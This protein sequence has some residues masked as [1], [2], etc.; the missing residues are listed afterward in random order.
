MA[1]QLFELGGRKCGGRAAADVKGADVQP[2]AVSSFTDGGQLFA[3]FIHVGLHEGAG[4]LIPHRAGDKAAIAAPR[5][6]ERDAR[7]DAA[8]H[9]VSGIQHG[10]L[11]IGNAERE[12]EF[13][14]CAAKMAEKFL[15]DGVLALPRCAQVVDDAHRA[16]AG[17]HAPGR[18]DAGRFTQQAKFELAQGVFGVS[19]GAAQIGAPVQAAVLA[20][21]DQVGQFVAFRQDK[22]LGLG[23]NFC[24]FSTGEKDTRRVLGF[25]TGSETA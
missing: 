14:R 15:S 3:Q 8:I 7:V 4:G 24:F 12:L 6:A 10:A 1:H 17:H 21:Q 9:R 13:L 20:Q 18:V 25:I 22:I 5:G 2:A 11:Q 23:Q 19:F 16:H